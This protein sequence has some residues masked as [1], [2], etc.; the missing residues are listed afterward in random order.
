[1][2]SFPEIFIVLCT[3]NI[4]K[5]TKKIDLSEKSCIFVTAIHPTAEAVGFLAALIIKITNEVPEE[6]AKVDL[7]ELFFGKTRNEND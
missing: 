7:D 2:Q 5:L 6:I 1:M 3:I 4:H